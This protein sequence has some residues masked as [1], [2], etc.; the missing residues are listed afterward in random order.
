MKCTKMCDL[1]LQRN[2]AKG[3]TSI[4]M[5]DNSLEPIWSPTGPVS[6]AG[7]GESQSDMDSTM[8]SGLAEETARRKMYPRE[9]WLAL[10]PLIYRLYITE[11]Q[12]FT[13]V[14]QHLYRYHEFNPTKKQFLR[15]AK[16]WG[17]EKNV[18][19]EERMAIL[20]TI[21]GEGQFEERILRGRK[22]DKA[23]IERW[24][25]REQAEDHWCSGPPTLRL[26]NQH[27][28]ANETAGN[29]EL[30][31][32]CDQGRSFN[33]WLAVDVI[34]SPRLTGLI[35]ALTLEQCG[36]VT[37]F[38]LSAPSH[39]NFEDKVDL[40]D[41]YEVGDPVLSQKARGAQ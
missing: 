24:R 3:E 7:L 34:G 29:R 20:E 35:G 28:M 26:R 19:K 33:P 23:K 6:S 10:K 21:D 37:A 8:G 27:K 15:K 31:P 36:D 5:H 2:F 12:T 22:L 39:G 38:D 1:P 40:L 41:T 17:F 16:E 9:Q 13:K 30:P 25:K 11:K 18:R 4:T 14:A 32:S